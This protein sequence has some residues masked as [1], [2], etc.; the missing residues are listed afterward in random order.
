[1]KTA[2]RARPALRWGIQPC[3]GRGVNLDVE[4]FVA[5]L[6]RE[7]VERR[8]VLQMNYVA[9]LFGPGRVHF[10]VENLHRTFQLLRLLLQGAGLYRRG[11]ANMLRFSIVRRDVPWA[12]LPPA[13]D[14]FRLLHLSDLHADA[15]P[16]FPDRLA[17]AL[18]PLEVDAVVLTGDYRM[19]TIGNYEPALAG[20]RRIVAA[21]HSPIFAVLGNHDFLEMVPALEAMGIQVLLNESA[22]IRRGAAT[23]HVAGIDDPHFYRTDDI[24]RAM[25]GIPAG[26]PTVLLAHS[27]E[28]HAAARQAEIRLMLCGHTHGGQFCLPGGIPLLTNAACPARMVAGA[29]RDGTLEGYTSRGTGCSGLPVRFHC[30]PE[31]VVHRLVR[32]D[33]RPG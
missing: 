16:D 24:P 9:R 28:I 12:G 25:A 4:R 31:I 3:Y 13:F 7:Y 29:W 22:A 5:R 32:C 19:A 15:H 33:P 6:G 23:L 26:D 14:G 17:A 18:A 27:P 20:M 2:G 1:M 11:V 21:L 30:P 8:L 10:H